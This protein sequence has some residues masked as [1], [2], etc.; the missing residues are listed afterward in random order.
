MMIFAFISNESKMKNYQ[1]EK[2]RLHLF[3]ILFDVRLK[4]GEVRVK[5]VAVRLEYMWST[6]K[7]ECRAG[8]V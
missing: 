5:Y 6:L 8:E 2:A 3:Q 7:Y 1:E 4:Y